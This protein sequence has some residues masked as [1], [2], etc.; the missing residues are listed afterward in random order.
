VFQEEVESVYPCIDSGYLAAN[1]P[2]I[3]EY[4]RNSET[5]LQSDMAPEPRQFDF[6]YKDF[7][8]AKVALA[9]AIVIEAHGK[10]E[11][12]TQMV[13]SVE[14]S[15]SRISKPAGDVKDLQILIVLVSI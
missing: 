14:R 1:A 8:L 4:G 15:V 11:N 13:E 5:A 6:S 10:R 3:L 12:S 7:Q 9:T 2:K